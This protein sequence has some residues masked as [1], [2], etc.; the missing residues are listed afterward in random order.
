MSIAP[1]LK[2]ESYITIDADLKEEVADLMHETP[3]P[4]SPTGRSMPMSIP[5]PLKPER[6]LNIYNTWVRA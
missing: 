3:S 6:T 1:N 4:Q 5:P 2:A